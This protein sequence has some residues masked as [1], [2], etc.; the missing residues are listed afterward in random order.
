MK[1]TVVT[2]NRRSFLAASAAALPAMATHAFAAPKADIT[3]GITV[4]TRPDWNGPENFMRSIK[5]AHEVG[6]HWIETFWQ[7][8]ERWQDNPGQLKDI[9]AGLN[10]RLETVSNGGKM[11]TAFADPAQRAGVIEDHMELVRFIHYFGCDHLKVN[12]GAPVHVSEADRPKMYHEMSVTFDEIG[13]R[14]ADMG[15]KFGIHAH[16]GS[17]FQTRR[18][19][20]AIMERTNPRWVWFVLDT[21]HISMAGMDPVELTRKYV[22]RIIEYHLKDV[23]KENRGGYKGPDL[24]PGTYNTNKENLIF[25]P[26]GKGGVDFPTIEKILNENQWH[27]WFT[28]ELDRT[29]ITAKE[30]A[31]ITKRYIETVLKLPV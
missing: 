27:G 16:L 9:L 22:S 31:A 12:C 10:L 20:D 6:Y 17:S 15:M 28:V 13:K 11:R 3:V 14:M 30:S 8:V 1:G 4:D 23:A 21:G 2:L 5:E 18:D 25:F 19:V 29:A 26:L 24:K 7:Y